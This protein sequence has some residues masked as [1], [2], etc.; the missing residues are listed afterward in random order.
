MRYLL[1]S[2]L[3]L[4]LLNAQEPV[5][6]TVN[7]PVGPVRGENAGDYNIVQ[8]WEFGYRYSLVG[9]DD[10]RYRSDV[11][12]TDGIRLLSSYLTVN[13]KDGHGKWFD[14]LVLTTQ[15]LGGDPYESATLR[16]QKNKLYRYDFHWR[17]NDY[18]DPGVTTSEGLHQQNL[19]QRWQDNDL[20]IF[21]DSKVQIKAGFSSNTETGPALSTIDLFENERGNVFPLFTDVKLS[22]NSFRLGANF[23]FFGIK[24]SVMHRWEYFE[25]DTPYTAGAEIGL[26][27]LTG[28]N[29]TSL[30][31][32]NRTQPIKGRTPGWLVNLMTDRHKYAVNGR[33]AYS[34]GTGTFVLDEGAIG[35][36]L[37]GTE[38]RMVNSYGTGQ[39]PVLNADLTASFFVTDRITITNSTS[40]T[41]TRMDGNNF[42]QE[43]DLANLTSSIVNFQFLG[44]RLITN[45]TDVHFHVTKKL[46]V[47]AG[48]RYADREIR[49][50]QSTSTPGTPFANTLYS[51]YDHVNAGVAGLNWKITGPL[52]L[53]LSTEIGRNDNPFFPVSEKNYQTIDGRLQYRHKSISASAGYKEYYNNNS[54]TLTSYDSHS[55]DYFGN[56]TWAATNWFSLDATYNRMHLDTAGG[57]AFFAAVPTTT[58]ETGESIY[59]S[60]IHA[61]NLG[62]RF[63]LRKKADLYL[64][65]SITKDVGDGRPSLLPTGTVA[66]LLYNVQTYPLTFESPVARLTI[67]ITNK[68]KW[69]AG[70]QY[71]GYNEQF[72]LYGILQNYH[73]HTGYTS[74]LFA[75]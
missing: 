32:F 59:I 64:G 70:Y 17:E 40:G 42:Y 11:N 61:G 51:Q 29:R 16:I 45:A 44:I 24:L 66:A 75:F 3:L 10:Q 34:D 26:P 14:E 65:Y 20:L 53:H 55:R 48:Y 33:F 41:D 31:S 7:E 18:F 38:N 25:D 69:N 28:V 13:S 62:A 8:S 37:A 22:Y 4:P 67:P 36:G 60:N 49:S 63:S 52:S 58:L 47:F 39:R 54:I 1:I 46:D 57:I 74:V 68:I 2:I 43:F 73:A 30:T 72:G 56:F 15:G 9:G 71:Y 27:P 6:P 5:A 23:N 21:P 35:T 19:T 50:I 12:Y